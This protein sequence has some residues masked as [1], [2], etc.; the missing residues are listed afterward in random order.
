MEALISGHT[1][2]ASTHSAISH[3]CRSVTRCV[4]EKKEEETLKII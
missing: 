3:G 2:D 1:W 4:C